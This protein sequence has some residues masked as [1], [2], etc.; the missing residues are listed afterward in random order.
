MRRVSSEVRDVLKFLDSKTLPKS[1]LGVLATLVH[2]EGSAYQKAGARLFVDAQGGIY[3]LVSGGCLEQAIVDE[4]IGVREKGEARLSTYDTGDPSDVD[5]G[6][7]MGCGGKLWVF[8]EAILNYSEL[9][10]KICGLAPRES[11]EAI[12]VGAEGLDTAL[13]G[14]RYFAATLSPA[15]AEAEASLAAGIKDLAASWKEGERSRLWSGQLAGQPLTVAL[16]KRPA[17]LHLTI[18]GAG[19]GAWPLAEMARTL[20]WDVR[21]FD[22]RPDYIEDFPAEL[23]QREAL[24]RDSLPDFFPFPYEKTAAVI[25]THNFSVDRMVLDK[26]LQEPWA[27]I[28]LLGSG[29]RCRTLISELQVKTG[30]DRNVYAPAGLTLGSDDVKGIALALIAEIS[31]VTQGKNAVGFRRD[32]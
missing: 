3:G 15:A 8:F 28:G 16:L 6:F 1:C 7:G 27:Y 13:L 10:Q 22:H 21:V 25:M 20:A 2:T 9:K 11:V 12:V 18:F 4:A 23:G 5:F 29:K 32:L 30:Q 14:Q 26:L 24:P 31:A 17:A 19:P